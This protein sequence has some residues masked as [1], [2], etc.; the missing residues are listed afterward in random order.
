MR[1]KPFSH[2]KELAALK[3]ISEAD[4]ARR[5]K[6]VLD[7]EEEL[8]LKEI[9]RE[10][11]RLEHEKA[12]SLKAIADAREVSR[13]KEM[14]AA[15]MLNVKKSISDVPVLDYSAFSVPCL[16]CRIQFKSKEALVRHERVNKTHADNV[17]AANNYK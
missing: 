9:A 14:A 13:L 15:D 3:E 6:A 11:A 12:A 4:E 10:D 17:K 2:A 16:L 7:A 8:R 5:Q 1:L